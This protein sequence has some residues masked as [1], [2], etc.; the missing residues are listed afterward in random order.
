MPISATHC[1]VL[2]RGKA[3]LASAVSKPRALQDTSPR[4]MTDVSP[5]AD[6][7]VSDAG[8][9]ENHDPH[10]AS[11]S[12]AEPA[13]CHDTASD[14]AARG[15]TD[16][17]SEGGLK[18][19][20]PGSG[21]TG[22][23]CI[24]PKQLKLGKASVSQLSGKLHAADQP[25]SR[26]LPTAPA[27]RSSIAVSRQSMSS[28]KAGVDGAWNHDVRVKLGRPDHKAKAT[29]GDKSGAKLVRTSAAAVG[30]TDARKSLSARSSD[31]ISDTAARDL[32]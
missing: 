5:R 19:P 17:A 24:V 1:A 14:T 32:E 31:R 12:D 26:R 10:T 4:L 22:S 30:I 27:R 8:A 15:S 29:A 18:R 13:G 23:R 21:S 20:L 6:P 28:S 7:S 9:N 2:C 25:V 16:T 11:Y 3:P